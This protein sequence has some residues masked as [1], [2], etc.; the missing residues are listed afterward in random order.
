[1]TAG[2]WHQVTEVLEEGASEPR[3]AVS[4]VWTLGRE[5]QPVEAWLDVFEGPEGRAATL[6]LEGALG[7]EPL[8]RLEQVLGQVLGCG[9]QRLVLDFSRVHHLDYR[10]LPRLVALLAERAKEGVSYAFVGLDRYLSDLFRMA[11]LEI[12]PEPSTGAHAE[13]G[14]AAAPGAAPRGAALEGSPGARE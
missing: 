8:E 6:A 7:A 14:A 13:C 2:Y 12:E 10:S 11:G 5:P 3:P 1:M 9:V 4:I